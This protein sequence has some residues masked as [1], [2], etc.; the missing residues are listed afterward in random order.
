[1][2]ALPARGVV[3]GIAWP[4][5]P[6]DPGAHLGALLFQLGRTEWLAPDALAGLQ[7]D[8]LRCLL[9]HACSNVPFYR[10]RYAGVEPSRL[11][12][13]TFRTLPVLTRRELQG[14]FERLQSG[15]VPRSHGAVMEGRTSGSTGTPVRFLQTAVTQLFWNALTLR[16]HLWQERDFSG[17]LAAIRVKVQEGRWPDWGPPAALLFR[18]GP[19][20]TLNVRTDVAQQLDWLQRVEPDY[21]ITHASN[22]QA[23]AELSLERAIRLPRLRQARTYSEALRPGLRETVR[24]AWGVEVA[25]VYSCEEAGVIALQCPSHAHYHVQSENLLVEILDEAGRPCEPGETGRVVVTTLHNFAMPLIRY[26]LGDYAEAGGPCDCGRGLPV[27]GRIL[28]RQRNML[29]LPDG[30]R[31][32]PSF[33]AQMWRDVAPV[34]QFQIIQ[35]TDGALVVRYVMAQ[36]LTPA[37]REA[38]ERALAERFGQRFAVRWQRVAQIPRGAGGKYEDF[39]SLLA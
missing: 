27:L 24:A 1:M 39:V 23:L 21:L 10:D 34:E 22:L 13:E 6:A 15:A 29:V 32:W 4:A 12:W 36:A 16:E 17:R 9:A 25:D 18:T 8:Q 28:G 30:R 26:E 20:A 38:L 7:L 35:E 19:G 11:D 33:P 14:G 2:T 37:Q 3:E 5:I 31:H